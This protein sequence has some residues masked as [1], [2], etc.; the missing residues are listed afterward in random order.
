[1]TEQEA[2]LTFHR[3]LIYFLG[4]LAQRDK[5]CVFVLF[6]NKLHTTNH[7]ETQ[8][9]ATNRDRMV[10]YTADDFTILLD[11]THVSTVALATKTTNMC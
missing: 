1:M 11:T 4:Y 10:R 6:V 2:T 8:T 9:T 3:T 5:S 7:I